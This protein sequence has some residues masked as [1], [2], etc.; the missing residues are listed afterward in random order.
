MAPITASF[1]AIVGALLTALAINTTRLR[2]RHGRNLTPEATESIRRASRA[3]G[4]T[5]EHGVPLLL[6]M[7]FAETHGAPHTWLCVIGTAFVVARFF[8]VYGMLTRPASTPMR[9]GAGSTYALEIVLLN[10]LVVTL[11][12]R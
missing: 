3:H 9:I 5:F 4:N 1:A 11:L 2:L 10:V 8:Y 12:H 7:F 6:L